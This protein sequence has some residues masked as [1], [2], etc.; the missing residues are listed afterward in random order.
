M[1][2]SSHERNPG[3]LV[4]IFF[5]IKTSIHLI[6]RTIRTRINLLADLSGRSSR[7][8]E[9]RLQKS[10]L[11]FGIVPHLSRFGCKARANYHINDTEGR[12]RGLPCNPLTVAPVKPTNVRVEQGTL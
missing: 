2:K 11:N 7:V 8:S 1:L 4:A 6:R 3:I 10:T 9:R 5:E 12:G